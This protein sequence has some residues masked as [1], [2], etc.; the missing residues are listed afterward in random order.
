MFLNNPST[1]HKSSEII[2][3]KIF[4][5]STSIKFFRKHTPPINKM[6]GVYQSA[7]LKIEKHLLNPTLVLYFCLQ[8]WSP[9]AK[10]A[11]CCSYSMWLLGI[12]EGGV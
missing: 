7:S 8:L 11:T 9:H 1:K 5:S 3:T 6:Y 12:N 4:I 10:E 2:H